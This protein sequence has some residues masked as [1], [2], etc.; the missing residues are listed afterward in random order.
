LRAFAGARLHGGT[1][2]SPVGPFLA[3]GDEVRGFQEPAARSLGRLV[4]VVG[5]LPPGIARLRR[6]LVM[7]SEGG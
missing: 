7:V 5:C 4:F 1:P 2:G 6:L 3:G